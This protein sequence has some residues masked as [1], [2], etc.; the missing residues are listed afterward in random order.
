MS[1]RQSGTR[2]RPRP[3]RVR[4]RARLFAK[5]SRGRSR[6]T[7]GFCLTR[8]V[9]GC[10]TCRG[11]RAIA[12]TTRSTCVVV[13]AGAGGCTLAQRLARRGWRVVVLESGPF[14]DPDR[15]W[16]SDEAGSSKLYWNE[17][18][19]IG[20]E[21][22]VE[23]GKNNSGHGVG[24]S[25]V[26]YAGYAPRFH[27]SDF[28]TRSLDGVGA[29]WPI[30]Y[31]DLKHA[32]RAWSRPSC[33]S[34]VRTGRGAIRT[35]TRTRRIR[36]PP[37][38]SARATG[39]RAAGI[40]IRV[41]PVAIANGAF[42]NRPHCIYRGFCLQGCKVNAK[43]SPLI[44]H[45]PDAIEH[46][47]EVRADSPRRLDRARDGQ[48]GAR[49]RLPPRRRGAAAARRRRRGRRLFDRDAAAA[50]ALD[51]LALPERDRQPGRPGRPL[52]DGAGRAAG[53]RPLPGAAR[54]CT[55]GR[56]RRSAP[57][58]STRPTRRAGSRAASRSRPS[59]RSRSRGPSTCSPTGT[60]DR[61]CASTCATTTTGSRSARCASCCR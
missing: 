7:R 13:G 9:A 22:P 14:W 8:I 4:Q 24:G 40:E 31:Q 35:A 28:R 42:G 20:G 55:R 5:G 2:P 44:T 34:P 36:S 27:P 17:P 46:G 50:A 12:T 45:L 26:H 1:S 29:D 49:R 30:S 3:S 51:Q 59:V 47:V 18:R 10:R 21:D 16:V 58:S 38:R 33:R 37:A 54:A 19:V 53:R 6:T 39:A 57:S 15:D 32:L 56:R 41:G 48:P 11:W 61:R 43:A 23:L 25:M 52:P 60:G